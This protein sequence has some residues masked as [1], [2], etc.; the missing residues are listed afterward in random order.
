MNI[1]VVG[2]MATQ[3]W[4]DETWLNLYFSQFNYCTRAKTVEFLYGTTHSG[5]CEGK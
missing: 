4:Q 1:Y 2:A 5:K 3:L